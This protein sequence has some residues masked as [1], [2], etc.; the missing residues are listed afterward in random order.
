MLHWK[1]KKLYPDLT[2][3][4]DYT[5]QNDGNGDYIRSWNTQLYKKP[6]DDELAKIDTTYDEQLYNI[7]AARTDAYPAIGDQLDSILKQLNYMQMSGQTD[8]IAELDDIV[9]A[10][11]KVKRDY[12]KP[13]E[14]K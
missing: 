6:T 13:E 12:P 9:G 1:L 2:L 5:L 7:R 4:V 10:W 3:D 14:T 8:L 11:L